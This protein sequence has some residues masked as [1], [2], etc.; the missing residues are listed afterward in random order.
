VFD[1]VEKYDGF[2]PNDIVGFEPI[3]RVGT[4]VG[5]LNGLVGAQPNP[6]QNMIN[7]TVRLE[8]WIGISKQ[9]PV[10]LRTDSPVDGL[11][12]QIKIPY[13]TCSAPNVNQNCDPVIIPATTGATNPTQTPSTSTTAGS[14]SPTST[15]SSTG[16]TSAPPGNNN[17]NSPSSAHPKMP[18]VVPI[19]LF[20]FLLCLF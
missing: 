19:I 7:G 1:R 2:P 17:G 8:V 20:M 6:F 16:S 13:I 5:T 9:A 10:F 12:T 11:T 14:S 18:S 3:T 15:S 4:P